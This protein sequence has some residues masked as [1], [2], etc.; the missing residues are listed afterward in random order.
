VFSRVIP[1]TVLGPPTLLVHGLGL[2]SWMWERDQ[3]RLAERGIASWAIDLPGHGSDVGSDVSVQD[4]VAAVHAAHDVV[5]EETGQKVVLI[6][7]SL[8]ALAVQMLFESGFGLLSGL[9]AGPAAHLLLRDLRQH[10]DDGGRA[11]TPR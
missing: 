1:N 9:R 11:D 5:A 7:H 6:G 3:A 4:I 8:G 2:G 10:G